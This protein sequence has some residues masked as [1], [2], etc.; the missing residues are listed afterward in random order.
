MKV[1]GRKRLIA[2][3]GVVSV[4]AGLAWLSILA[5]VRGPLYFA[6][7]PSFREIP[8]DRT[9]L[10]GKFQSYQSK[11]ETSEILGDSSYRWFEDV[12][13]TDP[14]PPPAGVQYEQIVAPEF[15]DLGFVGNLRLTFVNNRLASAH[16]STAETADY[17]QALSDHHSVPLAV[18]PDRRVA[19]GNLRIWHIGTRGGPFTVFSDGRIDREEA[20]LFAKYGD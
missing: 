19:K 20:I 14:N 12:A 7:L 8:P 3:L 16:F 10:I 1:T 13:W 5:L 15:Q 11:R 17:L 9:H 6:P 18:D 4:L 2:V